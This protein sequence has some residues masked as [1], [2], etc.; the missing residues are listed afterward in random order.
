MKILKLS[1]LS[2]ILSF[3]FV[4]NVQNAA[5]KVKPNTVVKKSYAE[6]NSE[7]GTMVYH[8]REIRNLY[9]A[10]PNNN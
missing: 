9:A 5:D 4:A 10:D 8:A 2:V 7:L 6:R 1:L 3:V